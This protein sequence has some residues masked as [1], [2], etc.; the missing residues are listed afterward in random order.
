[1]L[2][3]RVTKVILSAAL[4]LG[5]LTFPSATFA[6]SRCASVSHPYPNSRYSDVGLT[7]IR[8]TGLSCQTARRVA[9]GAHAKALGL[10]GSAVR[11][12]SWN[13]WK[14]T[15]YLSGATDRYVAARGSARVTWRF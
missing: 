14:I 8:A 12:F 11:R 4:V 5:I 6:S 1:M 9:K 7:R 10:P 2:H 15:G 3:A 13:G